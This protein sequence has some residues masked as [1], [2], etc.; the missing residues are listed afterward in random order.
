MPACVSGRIVDADVAV[1]A[2]NLVKGR[3]L[4]QAG[5]AVVAQANQSPALALKLLS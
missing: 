2:A 5:A 1:E 4:Q 3:I